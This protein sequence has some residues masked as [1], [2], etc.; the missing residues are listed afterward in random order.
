MTVVYVVF[1]SAVVFLATVY[2]FF[3]IWSSWLNA[4]TLPRYDPNLMWSH[5]ACATAA[6]VLIGCVSDG[7]EE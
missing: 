2:E 6:P 1:R 5:P 4:F 3:P 7:R